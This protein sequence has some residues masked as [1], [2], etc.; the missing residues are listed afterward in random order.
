M[1]EKKIALLTNGIF[2]YVIGGIQKHSFFLAKYFAKN[3]IKVDVYHFGN[4][5]NILLKDYFEKAELKYL[6]FIELKFPKVLKFP[7]HYIYESYLYSKGLY[8]LVSKEN[9]ECIYSQGLTA[10]YFL[11]THPFQENLISNLHGLNMFQNSINFRTRL[12]MLI[13][14][15]PAHRIIKN[16]QKQISLGGKLTNILYE[17]GA[18]KGSVIETPNGIDNLWIQGV[19][20]YKIFKA[21]KTIKFIF[22]GRYE[23]LKG[24]EEFQNIIVKTINSLEYSVDFIGPIPKEK[25]ID[26]ENVHYLG[27]IRDSE[28]IKEKLINAD[29]L[30]CPSYSEGMPTVILEAMACGCAI[31]CTDVGA[32]ST[33]VSED[34]GW[35]IY[36]GIEKGLEKYLTDAVKL[37]KKELSKMKINSIRKVKEEFTWEEVIKKTIKD[38]KN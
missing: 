7:G 12:E 19:N 28:L 35:L 38:M 37:S 33:M 18:I 6:N 34:N 16:S 9:Y 27:L 14:R 8:R 20:K 25:Q 30:V 26:H 1:I 29:I 31:I 2:P 21:E 5:E 32:N 23:R 13:L 15:I 11:K 36:G 4:D 10:W 22:V 17:N 3:L 24:I